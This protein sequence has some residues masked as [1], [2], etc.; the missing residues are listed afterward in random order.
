[1]SNSIVLNHHSLPFKSKD[2]AFDD[3][4]V[5]LSVLQSCRTYGLKILRVDEDQDKSLMRLE[6]ANGYFVSDWFATA[7]CKPEL[8]DWCRIIKSLETRQP[9]FESVDLDKVENTI[10]VG[11][12]EENSGKKVLLAAYHLNT[13]LV[14]FTALPD[15]RKSHIK[16]W[17]LNLELGQDLQE[18]I[19]FNLYDS[20]SLQKH[21]EIL[22]QR[23]NQ[24][25]DTANN[26]WLN[27]AD[28]FPHLTL[29]SNQIGTSLQ[30]WS[31]RSDIL[32]KARDALNVLELFSQKWLAGEYAEY[33]HEYLRDLGLAAEVSK[34]SQSISNDSRKKKERMFWLDDGRN[35]Y[36]ENHVKLPDGYR[37]HFYPDSM[38]RKIYVAYLGPHLT[39]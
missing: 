26:I 31:G 9:L 16:V 28:L 17:I 34:E 12:I 23:R 30:C 39:L 33:R 11:L 8:K 14:S 24:Q 19:L 35:V 32:M 13:F 3:F 22:I 7:N 27:R 25:L 21:Q 38:H 29:L 15:W 4:L 10:E 20:E 6:L 2:K 37:L 1:M 36:C 5:F 18:H